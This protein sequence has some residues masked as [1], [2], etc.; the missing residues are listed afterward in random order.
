MSGLATTACTSSCCVSST[1][2]HTA[3]N[4]FWE[5]DTIPCNLSKLCSASAYSGLMSWSCVLRRSKGHSGTTLS[6]M[7]SGP[8]ASKKARWMPLWSPLSKP[9][10]LSRVA[11]ASTSRTANSNGP[12]RMST[13]HSSASSV[14]P[15]CTSL[16]VKPCL[17]PAEAT[18]SAITCKLS[19]LGG[20]SASSRS[21]LLKRRRAQGSETR[22]LRCSANCKAS[23]NRFSSVTSEDKMASAVHSSSRS[24]L[25]SKP[26]L[27]RASEVFW[28]LLRVG[29]VG[30][31]NRHATAYFKVD[32]EHRT[33]AKPG[34]TSASRLGGGG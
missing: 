32:I 23:L 21:N 17:A 25:A 10:P 12:P 31:G 4:A 6:V 27:W 24:N 28:M 1:S 34:A 13:Q 14:T 9:P 18:F 5:S 7:F 8:P 22:P 20:S 16:S 33:E 3:S 29:D 2:S 15:T 26:R 30:V 19:S 11:K